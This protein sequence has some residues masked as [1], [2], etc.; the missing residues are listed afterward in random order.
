[1]LQASIGEFHLGLDAS[2]TAG[3]EAIGA[4]RDIAQQSRLPDPG[5]PAKHENAG[6]A[7]S[8]P[9]QERGEPTLFLSPPE[10]SMAG[11]I[12]SEGVAVSEP[13]IGEITAGHG[14]SPPPAVGKRTRAA[15]LDQHISPPIRHDNQG[16]PG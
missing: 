14:A 3:A 13:R 11:G 4:L 6:L 1:L 9:V 5:F 2:R 15:L 7:F 8:S 16:F 12:E 10:Q